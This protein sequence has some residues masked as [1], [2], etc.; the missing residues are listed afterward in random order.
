MFVSGL[1]GLSFFL[2]LLDN[3]FQEVVIQ[4]ALN[5]VVTTFTLHRV[6]VLRPCTRGDGG[7]RE[8]KE[9]RGDNLVIEFRER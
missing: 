3:N 9:T 6:L 2:E 8:T 4:L 1:L 7:R 5:E